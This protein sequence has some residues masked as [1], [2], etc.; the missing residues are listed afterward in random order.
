MKRKYPR[1]ILAVLVLV[2]VLTSMLGISDVPPGV[3]HDELEY[4]NNGYS[5][6]KT[7]RDLYGNFLPLTVGG[8]GYVAIPAYITGLTTFLFGLSEWSA[9]LPAAIFGMVEILLIYSISK[10]IFKSERIGLSAAFILALSTWGLKIS[11][12]MHESSVVLFLY[13]LG[14]YLFLSAKGFKRGLLSLVIL[15]LGTLS[16]YGSLFVFPFVL[17][18]IVIY[19]WDYIKKNEKKFAAGGGVVLLIFAIILSFMLFKPGESSRSL[20]RSG[21]LIIFKEKN[22]TDNVIYERSIALGP[23]FLNRMFVNKF[24]YVWRTFFS[25]YLEAFSPR[26]I[27]SQGDPNANYGLWGRGELSILDFPLFLMGLIYLGK[28]SKSGLLFVG[29]LVLAAPITSGLTGTVYATRAFLM[30]PFLMIICGGGLAFFYEWAFRIKKS[31]R[32]RYLL[33]FGFIILYL[34]FFFSRLHQYFLRYPVYAREAWFDSEKQLANYLIAH[35]NERIRIYSLEGRQMF[36]EYFFFARLDPEIAQAALD[37]HDI[38]ADI[39]IGNF[40]FINGCFDPLKDFSEIEESDMP[41]KVIV[42]T[43]CVPL[44]ISL[45]KD[46]IKARDGSSRVKWGI[47]SVKEIR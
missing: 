20:G 6:Y 16:Y 44:D 4:I 45:A 33:F 12:V 11:R 23:E 21:E 17:L 5:I 10:R 30:W 38:K 15:S 39:E 26:M 31:I 28:R 40:R 8:V 9:R 32:W 14:I 7:G 47:F 29:S 18:A 35:R 1:Y 46:L 42:N 22:M 43:H 36:M 3:S 24:I 19:R 2:T 41:E 27:F 34:F 13:L 25:N 37:K